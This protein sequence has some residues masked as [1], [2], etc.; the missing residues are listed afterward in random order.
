MTIRQYIRRRWLITTWGAGIAMIASLLLVR[1]LPPRQH[2]VIALYS[3]G[4]LFAFVVAQ[5]FVM[6]WTKCPRCAIP[7][8]WAASQ[9][10]FGVGKRAGACP[11][12]RVS[13]D[14]PINAVGK[15]L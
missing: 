10:A 12:C 8:G 2:L 14:A 1:S 5:A 9:A 4:A 15:A 7:L 3:L 6:Q 13:F 11:H